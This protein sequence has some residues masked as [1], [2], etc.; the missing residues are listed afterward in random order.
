M[1][2]N[3]LIAIMALGGLVKAAPPK[4]ADVAKIEAALPNAPASQDPGN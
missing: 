3:T 4:P 1:I 2:R